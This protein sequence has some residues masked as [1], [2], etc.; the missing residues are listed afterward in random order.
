VPVNCYCRKGCWFFCTTLI[1]SSACANQDPAC[2]PSE[3]NRFLAAGRKVLFTFPEGTLQGSKRTFSK[4]DNIKTL[5]LAGAASVA[6]NQGADNEIAQSFE[7]HSVFHGFTDRGFKTLGNPGFHFA[8]AGLWYMLAAENQNKAD[9]AKAQTMLKAL[10]INDLTIFSLKAIR[11]NRTPVG[12]HWAWPSGHTSSSF[13]LASVLDEFY[14]PQVGIPAYTLASLV[15]LRMMD[16]GDHWASDVVFGAA[17]GW[18]VGHSIAEKNRLPEIAGF[19]VLPYTSTKG[20]ST[21]GLNF[22]KQF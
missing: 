1:L 9:M 17:L 20:N 8:A 3:N 4:P 14:G 22:V 6:M 16:T 10:C 15:G 7:R 18:V 19:K 5:L 21:V 2:R 11:N 12:N 13:A